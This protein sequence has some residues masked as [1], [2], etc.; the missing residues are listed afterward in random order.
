VPPDRLIVLLLATAVL[1]T[2]RTSAGRIPP[3]VHTAA[4]QICTDLLDLIGGGVSS[5]AVLPADAPGGLAGDLPRIIVERSRAAGVSPALG[6]EECRAI[7]DGLFLNIA[8]LR[9]SRS[10]E[11]FLKVANVAAVVSLAARSR[12]PEVEIEAMLYGPTDALKPRRLVRVVPK[13][14]EIYAYLREPP[15]AML[16]LHVPSLARVSIDG[17]D[18]GS[19]A[20]DVRLLVP[21][22]SRSV[23]VAR[24]G[25]VPFR[26]DLRVESGEIVEV[27]VGIRHDEA[28]PLLALMAGAILPGLGGRLYAH[29]RPG[30]GSQAAQTVAA[31]GAVCFYA[32]LISW[33]S[34]KEAK[35][36]F[37]T[38]SAKREYGRIRDTELQVAAVGYAINLIGA[39]WAGV[40]YAARNRQLKGE[41]RREA[42]TLGGRWTTDFEDGQL[43]A[44]LAV[45]F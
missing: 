4:G 27:K 20:N 29:P 22:G 11:A 35:M 41:M 26:E 31:G 42:P 13:T 2:P 18:H 25:Y 39:L 32:G 5:I 36:R 12:Y 14:V 16:V 40:D 23:E 17:F 37:L 44:G 3:E 15:P 7:L 30:P 34:D 1:L 9:D 6:P 10:R 33:I 21:G 28:S 38:P 43:R 45:E 8:D 19:A 24:Y